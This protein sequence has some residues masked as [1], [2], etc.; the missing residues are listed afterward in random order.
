MF[1]AK[2]PLN[3]LYVSSVSV[4]EIRYGAEIRPM[5]TSRVLPVSEDILLRWCLLVEAGRKAGI[6]LS[7]PDLFIAA[8]AL[9]HDLTIVTRELAGF[10]RTGTEI[11]N[12]WTE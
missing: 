4:A 9:H 6:T 7:Q 2:E 5:F 1:L 3:R 12:P 8:T 10:E 11:L